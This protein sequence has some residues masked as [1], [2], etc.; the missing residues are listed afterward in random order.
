MNTAG[1]QWRSAAMHRKL[2]AFTLTLDLLAAGLDEV[3]V[4]VEATLGL[5]SSLLAVL[6]VGSNS[7]CSKLGRRL[8][9]G[10]SWLGGRS[11]GCW[12]LCTRL[13]NL[14]LWSCQLWGSLLRHVLFL[15]L[16]SRRC[17]DRRRRTALRG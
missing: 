1:L 4:S 8:G 17:L 10:D 16:L 2:A 5:D 11:L 15:F 7:C 12:G 6:S 3:H 14:G 9:L 13:G